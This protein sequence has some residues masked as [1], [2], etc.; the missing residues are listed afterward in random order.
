MIHIRV[1]PPVPRV[2]LHYNGELHKHKQ[3]KKKR[4]LTA[5]IIFLVSSCTHLAGMPLARLLLF[6]G[7]T[8]LLLK[9]RLPPFVTFV[10]CGEATQLK[11][12]VPTLFNVPSL[13][14]R[15]PEAAAEKDSL[16]NTSYSETKLSLKHYRQPVKPACSRRTTELTIT[17]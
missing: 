14:L 12:F 1:L 7:F 3:N 13:L 4:A 11:P 9:F 8:L 5:G 10:V 6:A 16:F 15:R 17:L 2:T